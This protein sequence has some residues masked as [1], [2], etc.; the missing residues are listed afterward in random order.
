VKVV[1]GLPDATLIYPGHE[2]TVKNLMFAADV[3]PDN[4]A[5]R[6]K[7]EESKEKAAHK[8]PTVPTTIAE[9]KVR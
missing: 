2:Y 7:L 9:E 4:D 1:G 3:E 6:A 8:Q 5:V